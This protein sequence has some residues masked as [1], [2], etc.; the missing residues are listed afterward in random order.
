MKSCFNTR[1]NIDNDY[2]LGYCRSY[3]GSLM[4]AYRNTKNYTIISYTILRIA[5]LEKL[6]CEKVRILYRVTN[7]LEEL[8]KIREYESIE[9]NYQ[10]QQLK[11]FSQIASSLSENVKTLKYNC[12]KTIDRGFF[13]L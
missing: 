11:T 2:S 13:G 10:I 8:K 9:R 6:Y 1:Y 12:N 4:V 3:V 5:S 7:N